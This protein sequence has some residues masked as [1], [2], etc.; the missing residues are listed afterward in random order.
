ML[1]R[2]SRSQK[3][4]KRTAFGWFRELAAD[5]GYLAFVAGEKGLPLAEGRTELARILKAA[6]GGLKLTREELPKAVAKQ[7]GLSPEQMI[8]ANQA[9]RAPRPPRWPAP[10]E[11]SAGRPRR[12]GSWSDHR[13]G[14]CPHRVLPA[15]ASGRDRS[16]P[17][18]NPFLLYSLDRSA[19]DPALEE[20]LPVG[21]A[22]K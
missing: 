19:S 5:P 15:S 18:R 16:R 11:P 22:G 2:L 17:R 7:E 20:D 13:T 8:A 1:T 14:S 12:R 10:S 9:R 21:Q 3:R 6:A 4:E